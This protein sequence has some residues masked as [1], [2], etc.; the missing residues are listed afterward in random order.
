MKDRMDLSLE[1]DHRTIRP[2]AKSVEADA[3]VGD[4][5]NERKSIES[6]LG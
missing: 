3:P 4:R 5:V 1:L 2:I 6:S